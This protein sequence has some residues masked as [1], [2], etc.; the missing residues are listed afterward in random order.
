M[1]DLTGPTDYLR[2]ARL[3]L[4]LSRHLNTTLDNV[5]EPA[6][7][8][9][10][11]HHMVLRTIQDGITPTP[12][13]VTEK[14]QIPPA[15]VSRILGRLQS[16]GFIER[17]IDATDQRRV[18]LSVSEAGAAAAADMQRAIAESLAATYAHVPVD[19]VRQANAELA[20]LDDALIRDD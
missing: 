11:K 5:L 10:L 15:S 3:V 4:R 14:L 7:D 6:F 2:L 18:L 9:T 20:T 19:V 12:G 1:R 17:V 13:A 16:R 8:L